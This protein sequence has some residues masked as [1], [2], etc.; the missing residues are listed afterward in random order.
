MDGRAEVGAST[1]R[2]WAQTNLRQLAP[3]GSGKRKF[4]NSMDSPPP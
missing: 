3:I 1:L 4:A 2:G